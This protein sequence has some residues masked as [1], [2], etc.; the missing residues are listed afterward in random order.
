M[1][2][3]HVIYIT[4]DVFQS[5]CDASLQIF[6]STSDRPGMNSTNASPMKVEPGISKR[7]SK[8][9]SEEEM[10]RLVFSINTQGRDRINWAEV[11]KILPGRTG[12]VF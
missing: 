3:L 2:L 5:F 10:Q 11:S 4:N 6:K 7:P 8:K 12:I 1:Q 9:W